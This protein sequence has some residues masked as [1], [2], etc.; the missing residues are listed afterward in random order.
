MDV[1]HEDRD[2]DRECHKDHG[3]KE[4]LTN[5]WYDEG[6][7]GDNLSD[8]QEKDLFI[9]HQLSSDARKVL[10]RNKK[11]IFFYYYE[12]IFCFHKNCEVEKIYLLN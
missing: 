4:I 11:V 6:R 9:K 5:K 8:D 10:L 12:C 1:Q 2:R 7:R 3:K